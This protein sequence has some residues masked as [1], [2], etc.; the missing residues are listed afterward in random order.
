MTTKARK[1]ILSALLPLYEKALGH[2]HREVAI[3]LNNLAG[4]LVWLGDNARAEALYREALRIY[5]KDRRAG[6]YPG[7]PD[8]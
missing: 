4:D 5:E 6:T 7:L 2:E 3:C 8:A 1:R